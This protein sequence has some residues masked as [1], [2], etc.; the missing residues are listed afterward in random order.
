MNR[1][2]LQVWAVHFL[3][4]VLLGEWER[5]GQDEVASSIRRERIFK[6]STD[7]PYQQRMM[8][9]TDQRSDR[10]TECFDK[11]FK[12]NRPALASLL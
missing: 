10:I 11:K 8:V 5:Q 7:G 4:A 2:N 9:V 12:T 1:G 6:G 3:V